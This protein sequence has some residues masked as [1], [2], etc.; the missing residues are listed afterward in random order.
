MD[1]TVRS[2]LSNV[3]I[4]AESSLTAGLLH[5]GSADFELVVL[6]LAGLTLPGDQALDEVFRLAPDLPVLVHQRDGTID[7]AIHLTRR[8]AFHVLLGEL[9]PQSF[10]EAVT[11]AIRKSQ[12]R[13]RLDPASAPWRHFLIG[14]SR[15]ML[16]VCEII[17]LVAAKRC[18]ILIGGETGTGKE[19]IAKA[20]HAASNRVSHP[21]VSVNCTALPA[22]L[23]ETELFGHA[24]GAFTGAYSSRVGRFEQAHRG[25][26]FLDEI[27][28]LPLDAQ[29]KLLRVLQEQEFQRIGSSETVKVDVRVIAA[30]NMDL[31][32]AVRDRHFR[33]DL[34][35]R[36]NV[37][38]MHLPPLRD[39]RE[40]IPLLLQH[41]LEKIRAAEGASPKQMSEEAI[42]FLQRMDWPGNVRQLEH[43]VQMA[44]A[45]S[46]DRPVL[47]PHDFV[48]RRVAQGDLRSNA[49]PPL[50]EL[51]HEG[52][53]FDEV[54]GTFELSLLN[55]ALAVSGG[56]KARAADLLKIKRTTLLAKM[57]SLTRMS[58]VHEAAASV[59]RLAQVRAKAA[60]Q[61][62]AAES[63]AGRPPT[64]L[65]LEPC[66]AIRRL[67][68]ALLEP[69][70]WR[71][72]AASSASE[73]LALVE[74]WKNQITLLIV[75]KELFA[76][77]GDVAAA[78]RRFIPEI[79]VVLLSAGEF[80]ETALPARPRT[81]VLPH[82]FSSED[83][84]EALEALNCR[85]TG[86]AGAL[87][88]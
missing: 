52:L 27:G 71:I 23:I 25:T 8:G 33:E 72:L 47:F 1:V 74:C 29:A 57:K 6:S 41:F 20:I 45:L 46:G 83:L 26:I 62:V 18:T 3:E 75:A 82:P 34:Y 68:T 37:V 53:D 2:A 61:R 55:Q 44:F 22:N 64:A 63:P 10:A 28:D 79:G 76:E 32:K 66:A 80:A 51:P 88:A 19:V 39:R 48:S 50:V 56:N 85:Q 67:A 87:C 78:C 40:D 30:S 81:R 36:L 54:V 84:A 86:Y 69:Q 21:L 15:P 49:R 14:Q 43:A 42:Q 38:P 73:A 5:L 7:D 77:P 60:A 13:L 4:L 9:A 17:Q 58:E 11:K 65:V 12:S 31:E 24:K 70:G 35:Y 16:H 59:E